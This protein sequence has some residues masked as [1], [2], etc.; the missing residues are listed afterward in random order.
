M[1]VEPVAD[2]WQAHTVSPQFVLYGSSCTMLD[3]TASL[4][5]KPRKQTPIQMRRRFFKM[6]LGLLWGVVLAVGPVI[7]QSAIAAE[8][9]DKP[10]DS[11]AG[12][13]GEIF[14]EA[15]GEDGPLRMMIDHASIIGHWDQES[16][17]RGKSI[18]LGHCVQCHGKNG[19]LTPN[20]TAR[21]FGKDPFQNGPDP[22]SLWYTLTK[23]LRNMPAQNWLSPDARYDVIHYL[24]EAIVKDLN[25]SQYARI[26]DAYL[27]KLPVEQVEYRP[28]WNGTITIPL[29]NGKALT[30]W[31]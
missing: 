6:E 23:G 21:A 19:L 25:P 8:G 16:Y 5:P 12:Q 20:K 1:L 27:E 18:Y 13:Q 22:L 4:S 31:S 14:V 24:R 11:T 17:E 10:K 28:S 29:L 7:H 9:S 30:D 2:F 3:A 15:S 26:D